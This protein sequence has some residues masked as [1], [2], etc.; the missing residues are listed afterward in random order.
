MGAL[1]FPLALALGI[2]FIL[3]APRVRAHLVLHVVLA[4]EVARVSG[5]GHIGQELAL[6]D[7]AAP[8]RHAA[9]RLLVIA[10]RLV[11]RF[12]WRF[13]LRCHVALSPFMSARAL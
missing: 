13:I 4:A 5:A 9:H 8:R 12:L 1:V 7:L 10:L 6:L 11:L 3:C 2:L